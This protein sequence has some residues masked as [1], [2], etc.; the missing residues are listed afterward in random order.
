MSQDW[1]A[2]TELVVVGAGGCGLMIAG[3]HAVAAIRGA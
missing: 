3:E 2:Q 1:D